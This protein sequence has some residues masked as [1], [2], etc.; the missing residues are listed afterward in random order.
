MDPRLVDSLSEGDFVFIKTSQNKYVSAQPNG[1][2]EFRDK[3]VEWETFQLIRKGKRKWAFRSCHNQ[4]L[5][6][7]SKDLVLFRAEIPLRKEAF[8]V[9]GDTLDQVSLFSKFHAFYLSATL[10]ELSCNQAQSIEKFALER[11]P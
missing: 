3:A 2:L 7:V 8:L 6:A 1:G 5:S 9:G 4:Y 11:K 10:K